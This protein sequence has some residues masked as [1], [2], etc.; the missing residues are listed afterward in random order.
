MKK[1]VKA[2]KQHECCSCDKPILIG[3]QYELVKCKCPRFDDDDKQVGIEF[4]SFKTCSTCVSEQ[5]KES[6]ELAI[7]IQSKEYKDSVAWEEHRYP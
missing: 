4:M 5:E 7:F 1:I 3:Q 6:E 2:R